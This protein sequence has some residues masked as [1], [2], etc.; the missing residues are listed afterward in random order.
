MKLFSFKLQWIIE[1]F[2][3][4]HFHKIF[5]ECSKKYPKI[6]IVTPCLTFCLLFLFVLWPTHDISN[7][8]RK[9]IFCLYTHDVL[10]GATVQKHFSLRPF[11]F[12]STD[13]AYLYNKRGNTD[14]IWQYDTR[15]YYS[16]SFHLIQLFSFSIWTPLIVPLLFTKCF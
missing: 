5:N 14:M 11:Q 8:A 2:N 4:V 16:C 10:R 1:L 7:N 12:A 3:K 9:T 15:W 13:P 6:E